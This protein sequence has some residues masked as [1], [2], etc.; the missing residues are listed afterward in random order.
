LI[1]FTDRI[2]DN[3]NHEKINKIAYNFTPSYAQSVRASLEYS[4]IPSVKRS[5]FQID[6]SRHSHDDY[7]INLSHS[8]AVISYGGDFIQDVKK[9]SWLIDNTNQSNV[10]YFF[11]FFEGNSAIV[12]WDSWRF[13]ESCACGAIPIHLDFIKYGFQLPS[14]PVPWK[15]YLP[16]DLEYPTKLLDEMV[17]MYS[18]DP[19]IFKNLGRVSRSWAISS[20][21]PIGMANY[22]LSQIKN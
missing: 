6:T 19:L 20:F 10:G 21:G 14:M 11:D 5:I 9:N 3:D 16:I 12:R 1:D 4:F 17:S 8:T 13:Y 7:L 15:H 22:F 18:S 2:L